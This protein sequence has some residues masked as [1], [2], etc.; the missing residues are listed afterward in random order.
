MSS[1]QPPRRSASE[2]RNLSRKQGNPYTTTSASM[3]RAQE[4]ARSGQALGAPVTTSGLRKD[5]SALTQDQIADILAHPTR[6]V[7]TEELRHDYG[8]VLRD[9]RSM[10]LLAGGLVIAELVLSFVLTR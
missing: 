8:Y 6:Q 1:N 2:R 5:K 9:I 3:R 10:F 4:R 7:T